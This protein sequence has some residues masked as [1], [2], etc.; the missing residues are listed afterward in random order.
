MLHIICYNYVKMNKYVKA[1]SNNNLSYILKGSATY[2]FKK[3]IVTRH[4]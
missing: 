1:R 3:K 4:Q 2:D